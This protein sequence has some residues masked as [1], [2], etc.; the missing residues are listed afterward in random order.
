MNQNDDDISCVTGVAGTN[1]SSFYTQHTGFN[2][3]EEFGHVADESQG[4][5]N[6]KRTPVALVNLQD[7]IETIIHQPSKWEDL[8]H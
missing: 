5:S 4:E 2:F 8:E 3:I 7:F 1:G 6:M